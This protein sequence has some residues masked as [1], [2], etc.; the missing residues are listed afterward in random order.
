MK[1]FLFMLFVLLASS[2]ACQQVDAQDQ[3]LDSIRNA[4]DLQRIESDGSTPPRNSIRRGATVTS[5]QPFKPTFLIQPLVQRKESPRGRIVEFEYEIESNL[6]STRLEIKTVGMKQ[7][8]NGVI[9]PNP[10]VLASTE[11]RLLTPENVSLAKGARHVARCR[12]T[13]PRNNNPFLAY[14]VLV[15]QLPDEG[16]RNIDEGTQVGIQFLSQY[17]LR[18]EVDVIGA[19]GDSISRMEVQSGELLAENGSALVTVFLNNTTD[20]AMEFQVRTELVS[21]ENGKSYRSKLF[22]PCRRNVDE[23]ER[24]DARIL[25]KTRLRMEGL[26]PTAVFPGDY[27][28]NVELLYKGRVL[29]RSQ[30]PVTIHS[31]D[32]PAQDATIVQV[33]KDI[34]IS[35]PS[36]ELSLRPGG[37]RI[38]SVTIENNSQQAI[39]A[40]LKS[41]KYVGDLVDWVNFR[42]S[43][44]ELAP[45]QKRKVLVTLGRKR[46]FPEHTYAFATVEV[47]PSIGQ[48]IGS[49]DIPIG[50]LTRSESEP[51]L[52]FGSLQWQP[53][54]RGFVFPVKNDGARHAALQAQMMLKDAFGRQLVFGGGYGAWLLPG[55]E[56]RLTF[57]MPQM[58]PP[59]DYQMTVMMSRG[60]GLDPIRLSQQITIQSSATPPPADDPGP[61]R[62]SR[63][64]AENEIRE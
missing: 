55:K 39:V 13:V 62:I 22:V 51:E 56:S 5:E 50:L 28:L 34:G 23:P 27:Q 15:K 32:F 19:R 21:V 8:E 35:P 40:T 31:G 61:D 63:G 10:D 33:A 47:R 29:K 52:K 1:P 6:K 44:I 25:P 11:A 3:L 30:F 58:P 46:D 18:A 59:G 53:K 36:L 41:K 37:R 64:D 54:P 42:P 38:Q 12:V 4:P 49:Q 45:G 7:E 26:L 57:A 48:A 17:L 60:K 14:G 43:E 2:V 24:Y 9:L 16:L 20:T